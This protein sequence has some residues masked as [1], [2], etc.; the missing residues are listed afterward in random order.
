MLHVTFYGCVQTV[1]SKAGLGSASGVL[2]KSQSIRIFYIR[3]CGATISCCTCSFAHSVH[4]LFNISTAS[5]VRA[6]TIY[7]IREY[8]YKYASSSSQHLMLNWKKINDYSFDNLYVY[9]CIKKKLDSMTSM[10]ASTQKKRLFSISRD[11]S[12]LFAETLNKMNTSC[13]VDTSDDV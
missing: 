4:G 3:E 12:K 2:R 7:I 9:N 1:A 6:N 5:H 10:Y 13:F 11:F 8:I